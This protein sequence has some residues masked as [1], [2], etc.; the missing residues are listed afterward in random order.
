MSVTI[1]SIPSI[2]DEPV[3]ALHGR[4]AQWCDFIDAK[5][6]ASMVLLCKQNN[7]AWAT[8]ARRA[9]YLLDFF[10]RHGSLD[11]LFVGKHQQ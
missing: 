4:I 5:S 8:K 2:S 1:Q 11:V 3:T 10:C 6:R 9:S 7:F